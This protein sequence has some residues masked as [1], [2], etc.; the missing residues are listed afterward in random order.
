MENCNGKTIS[1][2]LSTAMPKM[3]P[4]CAKHAKADNAINYIFMNG[5][6]WFEM[7]FKYFNSRIIWKCKS[8]YVQYVESKKYAYFS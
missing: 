3:K 5:K 8:I 1:M 6:P 2:E 4:N 7:N